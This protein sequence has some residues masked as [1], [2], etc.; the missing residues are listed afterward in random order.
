VT[1]EQ[2]AATYDRIAQHWDHPGFNHSNGIPQHERALAFVPTGRTALDVGCGSNG[3]IIAMLLDR[4]FQV[5]G[6]D[7]SSE[8][9]DRARRHHPDVTFHQADIVTWEFTTRF[10][11]LS[12]WDSIWHVPLADQVGVIRKL[13]AGLAP[14]GVL[15]FSSGGVD[16]PHEVSGPCFGH[17][18]YHA[19][20]GIPAL[21]RTIEASGCALRHFEFDAGPN[22]K[23]V[24][25]IVQRSR[26]DL[27]PDT[28]AAG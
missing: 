26:C 21:L 10:D 16:E 12:A 24:Y 19:T 13:C 7:L 9:L 1:P 18:L 14:D 28:N 27:S 17:P 6:L 3:R 15:I 20:P 23:H 22:E 5:E 11:F 4:G 8:M 2:T 25:L